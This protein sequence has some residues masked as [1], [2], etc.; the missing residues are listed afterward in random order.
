MKISVIGSGRWGTFLA[1]Y[2]SRVFN[3]VT[4]Y[5]RL[6]SEKF[7]NL[8]KNRKNEYLQLSDNIS[9][10]SD[11]T[12]TLDG[13]EFVI[14][15][16]GA[17]NLRALAKELNEYDLSGK[18]LIL[19]MKGMEKTTGKRLTQVIKDEITQDVD[20]AVWLGPGHV[21]EFVSHIP[22]CMVIDSEKPEVIEKVISKFDSD[23]IRFYYGQDLIGTEIGAA[24]KNILGIA[25]GIL[26][27]LGFSSLKGALMAR[28]TREVSR[29][30][31]GMGGNHLSAYGLA[32]LGDYEATLFSKHSHNRRYGESMVSGEKM[33]KLAEGVD[34]IKAVYGLS[35]E[36]GIP[37]P[38]TEA[39]YLV[40]FENHDLKETF[41]ELFKRR[42][43]P[44]FLTSK[45]YKD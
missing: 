31:E 44:E 45:E 1:W 8:Q 11:I 2:A 23:L 34:T 3:N 38:I 41:G 43:K 35:Q 42:A 32:H 6:S 21:Q 28:G 10:S 13:S 15:S 26:D 22:N 14:I 4:L 16:I 29:L 25:A 7:Q 5:G 9:L 30:I 27:G 33:A 17:Q 37:M 24:T 40:I 19:C 18:T 20:V 39:L 12:E 36:K